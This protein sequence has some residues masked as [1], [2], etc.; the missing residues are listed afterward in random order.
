MRVLLSTL[1][2]LAVSLVLLR[3]LPRLPFG[4]RLVLQSTLATG[5]PAPAAADERGRG[6]RG[7]AV[8]PLRPAGIANIGG[9]RIDVVSEG[10]F[11]EPGEPIE[12]IRVEG[13]RVVVRHPH[14]YVKG[15]S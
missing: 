1:L 8:S 10:D 11:I 4:N 13:H 2:A 9:E 7:T 15:G 14:D 3:W 5:V 6:R 12:V